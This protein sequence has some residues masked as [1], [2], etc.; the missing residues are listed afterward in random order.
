[1]GQAATDEGPLG[2]ILY[3][4]LVNGL[5][6]FD[7]LVENPRLLLIFLEK[8]VE[9]QEQG[10]ALL[11]RSPH[12]FKDLPVFIFFCK[13]ESHLELQEADHLEHVAPRGQLLH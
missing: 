13:L 10:R 5:V 8:E 9:E 3:P 2:A 6:V 1:M 7:D 12:N 4:E 11:L